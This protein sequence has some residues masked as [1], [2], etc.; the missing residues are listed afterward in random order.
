MKLEEKQKI[1]DIVNGIIYNNN[2]DYN[3]TTEELTIYLSY[4][5]DNL[6]LSLKEQR[7]LWNVLNQAQHIGL[8]SLGNT[9]KQLENMDKN[10]IK[11]WIH[12]TQE[13]YELIN[14]LKA[15]LCGDLE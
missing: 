15:K 2:G 7:V 9:L 11:D 6:I 3:S 10:V 5:L 14:T 12:Q 4:E 1:I 13:E 8:Q